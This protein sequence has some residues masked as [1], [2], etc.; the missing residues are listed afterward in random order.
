MD[1]EI[2]NLEIDPIWTSSRTARQIHALGE[3]DKDITR[4]LA[5]AA[6]SIS[7]LT[8]PQTD[9]PDDNLPQ[10]EER[11]EQFVLEVSEYFE[12][13]DSIQVALRSSLAHIRHSRI[14]PS[15][16]NAPPPGFIPP[17]LGVG[18]PTEG[19][20]Q[21]NRGLQ[22]ERVDHDAW[23]GILAAL[24]RVKEARDKHSTDSTAAEEETRMQ[25]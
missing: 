25:E 3:V 10:G 23:K 12:R 14:A 1:Q 4:L 18:L 8:L 21:S 9:S 5:L 20:S 15:A 13:L 17:S 22:E 7:L 2:D 6:S 24:M 11:S 16:I 19:S